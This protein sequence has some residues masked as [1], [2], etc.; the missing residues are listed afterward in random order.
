[1]HSNSY[2]YLI[3]CYS[4][5]FSSFSLAFAM[6]AISSSTCFIDVLSIKYRPI[7]EVNRNLDNSD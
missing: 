3:V 4:S 1:M 7:G 6:S 2:R 5:P